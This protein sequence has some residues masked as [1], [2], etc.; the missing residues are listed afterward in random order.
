MALEVRLSSKGQVVLPKEIRKKLGLRK[1]DKL[2]V[3]IDEGKN[4]VIHSSLEPPREIFIRAGTKLTSQILNES[5]EL[6]EAKVKKLLK[7]IGAR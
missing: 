6:D 2:R 3:E 5:A 4:I 1:G 7:A